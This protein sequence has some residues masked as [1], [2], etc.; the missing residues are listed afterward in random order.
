[1][2]G[3]N[4]GHDNQRRLSA[5]DQ[6]LAGLQ[7]RLPRDEETPTAPQRPSPAQHTE[8]DT[9]LSPAERRHAAGLMRVN[10]AGEVAAQALYQG[11]ALTARSRE[12]RQHL[13]QAAAEEQDHLHWCEQRLA[14]LEAQPSLLDP[15]WYAGSFALGAAAGLVSDRVSLGFVAETERQVAAHLQDHL[16]RLP[17]TDIESRRIVEQMHA[18]ET[19]HG[20]E[21]LAMGGV[22]LPPLVRRLMQATARIMTRTAYHL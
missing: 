3:M 13:Q 20:E 22:P 10:H 9:E 7:S 11:Q 15:L 14:A 21:A 2:R 18:D 4:S 12:V 19:R 1:M 5:L 6:L 8:T 16:Q 17:D